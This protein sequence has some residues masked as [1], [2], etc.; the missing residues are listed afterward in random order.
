MAPPVAIKDLFT[1]QANL[2]RPVQHERRLGHNDLV[3]ERIALASKT[4]AVGRGNH[5]N[6]CRGH[7]Q[8]LGKS[9]V[10]VV[11]RLRAGPDCQLPIG[12][13]DGHRGVLLDR[14]MRIPLIEKTV[15]E[16]FIRFGKAFFHIP[17][18][19]RHQLVN[20]AFFPVFVDSRLRSR[21][22]F[23]GVRY[24]LQNFILDVDQVQSFKC[25]EFLSRDDRSDRISN[26]PHMI[27]RSLPVSTRY[28]PGQ[29]S[30]RDAS[31]FRM[32]A[33]GCGD[34]SSLQCAI[35]GRKMSSAKRVWPVTFARASTR[36]RGTPI[37]RNS[38]PFAF[39]WLS[40]DFVESFSSGIHP[41]CSLSDRNRSAETKSQS[42]FALRS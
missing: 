23:L 13:L 12:I 37:T 41:P 39:E 25:S 20:V 14:K 4:S 22:S 32:R 8:N 17:K 36:R 26:M 42:C 1:R 6:M 34:R 40:V 19:Q 5:T 35:R 28:T 21:Q 18:L 3:I 31:I 2:D 16:D 15:F 7:L 30:A 27:G 33:W 24:R 9:A 10:K 38:C 29:A 11:R